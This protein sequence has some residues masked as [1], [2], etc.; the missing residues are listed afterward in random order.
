M[1][2]FSV[3]LPGS[4]NKVGLG[5]NIVFWGDF[6]AQ[7]NISQQCLHTYNLDHTQLE[8][9]HFHRNAV[10]LSATTLEKKYIFTSIV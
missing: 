9:I 2:M 1:I 3:T 7:H 6:L 4:I 10:F 5:Q 8:N